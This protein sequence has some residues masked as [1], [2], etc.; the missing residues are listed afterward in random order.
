MDHYAESHQTPVNKALHF[1]GIPLLTVSLLGLLAKVHLPAAWEEEEEFRPDLAWLALAGSGLW[2]LWQDW[3]A[4]LV[5]TAA[6]V[7]CYAAGRALTAVPLTALFGAGVVA[8]VIGHYGFEGK[9]PALLSKPIA[10]L[11]APAWLLATW[12]G[13]R[14]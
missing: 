5:V 9:P 8:H 4:G 1:V 7:G 10:V 12:A 3:K 13:L 2:Y 11:E 14:R 6:L